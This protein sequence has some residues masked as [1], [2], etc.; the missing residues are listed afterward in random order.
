MYHSNKSKYAAQKK[1]AGFTLFEILLYLG[2]SVIMVSLISAIGVNVMSSMASA[3]AE[4]DLQYNAQFV[5]EKLRILVGEAESIAFPVAGEASTTLSLVM[6]DPVKNPT[7]IDVVD[8]NVRVRA[9]G[10]TK[11]LLGENFLASGVEFYN[12][13][14]GGG[15][16]SVRVVLPISLPNLGSR[17]FLRASSTLQTTF[18]LQYP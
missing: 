4:E 9:G 6:S 11:F 15:S 8:G 18:S 17:A 14:Y 2:L 5:T 3:K 13:T 10:E 16:G 12:V 7:I 1:L